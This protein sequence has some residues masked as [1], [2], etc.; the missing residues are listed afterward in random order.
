MAGQGGADKT[1][2]RAADSAA[3]QTAQGNAAPISEQLDRLSVA[4]IETAL[5]LL[6]AGDELPVMLAADCSEQL[7]LFSDDT[8]DGCYRA[9]CEQVAALGADCTRYVLLYDGVVQEDEAGASVAALLFEF[10]ERGMAHAW[11]G[12]LP[13]E[14]DEGGGVRT[15]ELFAGGEERLLFA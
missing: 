4:T 13:Y 10:A 2:E 3:A 11:S 1:T 5:D 9:G 8:P 12:C 14:R 6:E 7:Y 15:G